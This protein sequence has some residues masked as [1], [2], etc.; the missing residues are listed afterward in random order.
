MRIV[1]DLQGAQSSGSRNRGIGRYTMSLSKAVIKNRGEHEIFL[2]LNGLFSETLE[3]IRAA[4]EGLLPQENILVWNAQSPV[5]SLST[6][7]NWRRKTAELVREAF[8]ANL[9]PDMVLVTSLFEGLTDDAITSIGSL[10][11]DIPTSVILY[12]LIPFINRSPYLENPL[13]EDWYENKIDHLRRANLLLTISDSSRQ[14][15]VVHL[16]FPEEYSVNIST[17]ADPQFQPKKIDTKKEKEIRR[18][19][20]LTRPF[21]MYTGGIDHR[22]NIEGLIRSYAKL[23]KS[24]R[25]SHQLAIVCSI[26]PQNRAALQALAKEHGLKDNELVLTGFVPE[27]DLIALYNLCKTFIFPSWHEG[28][29]L[30]ALEAMCCG[31]AVIGSNTSSLPEV[32]GCEEALFDPLSDESIANK[33]SQVLSD[34]EFRQRL[35]RNGL[36][37]AKHFTWDSSAKNAI[38]AIEAW[39]IN[40]KVVSSARLSSGHRPKLA[41]ISPLPP[42]RSGISDY[43][44]ELLPEL[45]RHYDIEVIVAQDSI[46]DPWIRVNCVVRTVEWFKAHSNRYDRVLYHFGNS[47]FHQHMFDLLAEIP[48]V[49]VLHDFFLSGIAAHMDFTGYLPGSWASELYKSHGYEAVKQRFHTNDS[50]EIIWRYPC[51][52]SVLRNSLGVIVHSENSRQLLKKWYGANEVNEWAV[53]PLLR[54]PA[55][56]SKKSLARRSLG[57]SDDDF[58]VCSF[59]MLAQTKLNHRLLEAWFA[60]ALAKNRKCFLIFA[61]EQNGGYGN[62]ILE[63]IN[64]SGLKDRIRVT[65]WTDMASFR[66][67]LSAADVGVQL[68]TL[69]RG[70]TSAAVLDCMNYGLPTIV[71]ANGSMADLPDA[72]VWKLPDDFE[73]KQ[74]VEALETLW[75]N[76]ALRRELG[77]K[78]KYIMRTNHAPRVCADHYAHS[79]ESI[80]RSTKKDILGLNNALAAVEPIQTAFDAWKNL[81]SA[82]A[83]SI[84]QKYQARQIFVDISELVSRDGKTGIQ[85]VVR[86]IL[87]ELLC[88]PPDGYRIEPVYATPEKSYFYARCFTLSFLNCPSSSLIDE[89]IDFRSGDLFLGLDFR[90]EVVLRQADFY[91]KLRN[92]GVQVN[93]VVY[94]LLPITQSHNFMGGANDWIQ[95]WL[96]VIAQCDGALCISKKVAADLFDWLQENGPERQRSFNIGY[97]HLGADI[98]SSK[99]TKGYPEDAEKLLRSINSCPT[100]LMVGTIEPRKN[101]AQVLEAFENLWAQ[102]LKINLVIVGKSGWMLESFIKK[103]KNHLYNGLQLFWLE[104]VSDE[105]LEKLYA[106]STCLIA[107]S[108]GEGFGLPLIEAAQHD[109][110]IIARDIPEFREVAGENALYFSGFDA[111]DL[112]KAVNYWLLLHKMGKSP[113]SSLIP[114]LTWAQSARRFLNVVLNNEYIYR[115][116]PDGRYRYHVGSDARLLTQVGKREGLNIQ[117]TG[118]SGYLIHGP[119]LQLQPG[120]YQVRIYGKVGSLGLPKAYLDATVQKGNNILSLCNL[121]ESSETGLIAEMKVY[122]PTAFDDFEVRV[123]VAADSILD[124]NKVEILPYSLFDNKA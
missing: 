13:V 54:R 96:Q 116:I 90:P 78:S 19:Y 123:W 10:S 85:R 119:Y 60:S 43:S 27:E 22:K 94:D 38:A 111:G 40:N 75:K 15:S 64:K 31:R 102:G 105:F 73:D 62:Q 14:E 93:F 124:I 91:Q 32:I 55:H 110:P 109:L 80:Y 34:D 59:G 77:E 113:Q 30:P 107:S 70:E 121:Q 69:S 66:N 57:F 48:G 118:V 7:N 49:V 92:H 51:N 26:Q 63:T 100:F 101:H 122:L 76:E 33:L 74:L 29:G 11:L 56:E 68:R 44:A 95:R 114:W 89:P 87:A 53:I 52:L 58:L 108:E 61:G 36:K 3:P 21:V 5:N 117:T 4:F 97:F 84:P 12:D 41:Y 104:N 46:S 120:S 72:A 17:A 35:E 103:I 47:H 20:G 2:A 86:S 65:G 1:I 112:V 16:N 23:E 83:I 82:V 99:P 42:E 45:A 18:N 81:A 98:D 67:Y 9:K 24:L 88:N 79:I 8:L 28:F 6:D 71:N 106:N 39:H 50:S 37:K 115:W 25:D